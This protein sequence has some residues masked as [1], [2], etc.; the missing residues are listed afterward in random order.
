MIAELKAQ[1][2]KLN[3]VQDDLEKAHERVRDKVERQVPQDVWS[4]TDLKSF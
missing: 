1:M 3:K 2:E 4:F